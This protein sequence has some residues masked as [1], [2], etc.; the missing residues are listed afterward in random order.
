MKE[1]FEKEGKRSETLPLE[2]GGTRVGVKQ[3]RDIA[4]R[5][6]RGRLC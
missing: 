4:K 5:L 1:L 6:R 3:L 2:G